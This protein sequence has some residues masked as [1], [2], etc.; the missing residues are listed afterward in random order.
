LKTKRQINKKITS[1]N[2]FLSS[3]VQSPNALMWTLKYSSPGAEVM[4]NGCLNH[5]H[6]KMT[7]IKI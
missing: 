7:M 3:E 2:L 6:T 4:E 1:A 5:T